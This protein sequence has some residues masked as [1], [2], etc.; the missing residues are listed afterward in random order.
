MSKIALK[1]VA[2]VY[3]PAKYCLELMKEYTSAFKSNGIRVDTIWV[4]ELSRGDVDG[5]D[6]VVA[7]GGDGTL[8]RISWSLR[9]RLPLILPIPCGRRTVLYEELD[10]VDPYNVVARV[11]E[12]KFFIDRVERLKAS[13]L[14]QE[15]YAL[16]EVALISHDSGRALLLEV[17][18]TTPFNK[19]KF[20]L[21]SDGILVSTSTGSSAYALSAKGP[22]IETRLHTLLIVPLNPITLN[23]APL[24]LH[25]FSRVKVY[26]SDYTNAY[27]DGKNVGLL[28]PRSTAYFRL[29]NNFLRIVRLGEKR[30]LVKRVLESRTTKFA[31]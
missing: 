1:N 4:D 18:I 21:E 26:L 15:Y 6:L 27:V 7:M 20:F 9:E 13:I 30:D 11:I 10:K 25:P 14:G 5:Y 8:L 2:I 12:G 22:L 28:P 17:D 19:T 31:T 16:N 3:K 29:C 24:V 23:M